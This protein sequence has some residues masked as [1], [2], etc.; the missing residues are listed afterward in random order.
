MSA[1]H[2]KVKKT[3]L[4]QKGKKFAAVVL[5]ILTALTSMGIL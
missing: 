1:K 5:F 4:G 3:N 2:D